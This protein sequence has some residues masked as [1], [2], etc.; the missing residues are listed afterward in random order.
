MPAIRFTC[1]TQA[2]WEKLEETCDGPRLHS[3]PVG[4]GMDP[5][6]QCEAIRRAPMRLG[7]N[8]PRETQLG[9]TEIVWYIA[10]HS[11]WGRDRPWQLWKLHAE[12]FP[13]VLVT[14]DKP[15]SASNLSTRVLP[16]MR[17]LEFLETHKWSASLMAF[18]FCLIQHTYACCLGH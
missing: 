11:Y 5:E 3:D 12:A 10:A 16:A 7:G 15:G 9:M 17:D 8:G 18:L 4:V 2:T 1:P 14:V 6:G 13:V